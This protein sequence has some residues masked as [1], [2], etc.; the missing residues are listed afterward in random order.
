MNIKKKNSI[1]IVDDERDNISS[2]KAILSPD[3]T[4]YASTNGRDAIETAEEFIP[5]LILL[6]IL[7]PDM[8]GYDVITAFKNSEKTRDIPVIFITGLDNINAEIKGLTLGAADY[9]IKPF[10]PVI[11][12]LRIHHHMQLA[13]RIH[14]Q[15]LMTKIAHNFLAHAYSDSLYTESLR[16]AGEFMGIA[17]ILLYQL[18]NNK[19]ELICKNEWLNPELNLQSSID[20]KI[21]LDEQ[22]ISA[23]NNLLTGN[24]KNLCFH[25][26]DALIKKYIK[27]SSEYPDNSIITPIYIKGKMCSI[28]IFSKEEDKEWDEGEESLAILFASIFSGVF[29]R[30]SIQHEEYLNRAKSEFLSRMSHE[31]R[32][33][34]NAIIGMLQ[35]FDIV[36]VPENLKENCRIMNTSA[37]TLMRIIEDVLDITDMGYGSFKLKETSFDFKMMV[38]ELL[39]NADNNASKKQQI[40]N[41]K[42]DPSIPSPLLGDAKRLKQVITTMLANAVKFTP[43]DGEINFDARAINEENGVVTLQIEVSDNGIGISKEQQNKLFS[44]FEQGDSSIN[45]EFGGIGIG[46]ALSKRIIDMMGGKIWVEAELGKGAKFYF[47]CKL[48]R[49]I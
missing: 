17:A 35:V 46:L 24:E 36:G 39:R 30:D 6:D 19:N 44:I 16:M 37:H 28:L 43:D 45:R 18:K 1:L 23:I 47:T 25:S 34:M 26:N 20:G 29:E 3:Y 2:L 42:I 8:D 33:P 21:E 41:C 27:T 32:T 12:K 38:R 49:D 11:I 48:K 14:Q 40:L 13:E 5:D 4:V 10:H 15:A 9:I 7:M 31:M 22:I